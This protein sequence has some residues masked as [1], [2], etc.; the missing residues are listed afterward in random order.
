ME[1]K[2]ITG[3]VSSVV[4]C[5]ASF[6]LL[7]CPFLV[8]DSV[9][10]NYDLLRDNTAYRVKYSLLV[11]G[12][13]SKGGMSTLMFYPLFLARRLL[14]SAILVLCPQYPSIQLAT[15]AISSAAVNYIFY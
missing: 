9:V 13:K 6:F 14:C 1:F 7:F 5:L 11:Q 3:A 4:A 8:G 2:S 10:A 12:F 15:M